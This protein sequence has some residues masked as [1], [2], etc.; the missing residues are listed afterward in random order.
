MTHNKKQSSD[1]E[2]TEQFEGSKG[3]RAGGKTD[4]IESGNAN[5]SDMG[6]FGGEAANQ[7]QTEDDMTDV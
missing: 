6:E 4:E 2:N 5:Y 1:F 3:G 7:N